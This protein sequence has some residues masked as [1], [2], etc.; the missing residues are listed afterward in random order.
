MP[1]PI[2]L[3]PPP[4]AGLSPHP[5]LPHRRPGRL[6]PW[7]ATRCGDRPVPL[8]RLPRP[9][10]PALPTPGL[11]GLVRAPARGGA[12]GDLPPPGLHPARHVLDGWVEVHPK[13]IY[14]LL[15]ETVWATL[16]AFGADPKRLDGQL[17]M[18]AMLHTWG[19]TLVRHV[20]LHCLVPGGA[21]GAGGTGTRPRAPTCS[22]CGPCRG[23][24]AAGSS[25][26]C[27]APSRPARCRACAT[28]GG[29]ARARRPD[30]DRLGG[31]LQAGPRPHR[32]GGGLSGPLQPPHRLARQPP[33]RL[34]RRGRSTWPTRTT[35][36][37][38]GAR[39]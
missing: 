1:T 17:G 25:A 38:T 11:A 28:G 6:C 23:T 14:A 35:A 36:T 20:H 13:E 37:V 15:F 12:A 19:Q 34:R 24:S 3:Q 30:G 9:P 4:V 18:T 22:R 8:P 2:G 16:S 29:R 10:L 33:A 5:G 7:P 27:A 39:S 21:L 32:D 31:L 26:G